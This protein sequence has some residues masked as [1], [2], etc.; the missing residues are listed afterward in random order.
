MIKCLKMYIIV[1]GL[2]GDDE[3]SSYHIINADAVV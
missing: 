1:G 3:K 2:S